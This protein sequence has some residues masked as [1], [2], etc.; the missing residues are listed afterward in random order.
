MDAMDGFTFA[1]I[2]S[3]YPSYNHIPII[4]L[5]ATSASGDKL[6]GLSLCAIDFIQKPFQINELLQKIESILINAD[7]QKQSLLNGVFKS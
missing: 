6:H 2:I 1:K 4:F 3:G 5:S 7:K